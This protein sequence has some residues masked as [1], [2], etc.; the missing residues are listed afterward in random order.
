M[1]QTKSKWNYFFIKSAGDSPFLLS[2]KTNSSTQMYK[3]KK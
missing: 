1:N 2:F 3:L